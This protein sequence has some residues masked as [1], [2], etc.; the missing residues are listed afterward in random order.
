MGDSPLIR[1]CFLT[2]GLVLVMAGCGTVSTAGHK[3]A[4]SSPV[5]TVR[6]PAP[7]STYTAPAP[8]PTYTAPA[9]ISTYTAPA[10]APTDSV[11]NCNLLGGGT[12]ND[13]YQLGLITRL[14]YVEGCAPLTIGPF[15]NR[16][17][18][19]TLSANPGPGAFAG[20]HFTLTPDA[21][22]PVYE[23][24]ESTNGYIYRNTSAGTLVGTAP[25]YTGFLQPLSQQLTAGTYVL[26]EEEED[27]N[28][29]TTPGYSIIIG[30][31]YSH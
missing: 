4:T 8:A 23:A 15:Q 30:P 24:L 25:D 26:E 19:F 20:V 18:S 27:I 3:P 14:T 29:A 1:N 13:P 10:P 12:V 6:T 9:P 28:S 5:R 16:F 2:L 17:F 11:L 21:T 22:G 31:E 7:I